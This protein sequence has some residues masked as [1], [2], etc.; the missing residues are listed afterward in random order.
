MSKYRIAILPGDGVGKDVVEATMIVLNK[1]G[2]RRR[3]RLRRHRLGVLVQGGERPARPDHQAAQGDRRLPLRG[4]HLQAQGGRRRPSSTRRSGARACPISAPSSACARNSTSTHEP[5]ALQGLSRQSPQLQGRHRPGHLP[6]EHRGHVR[7]RRVLPPA[8]RSS[9]TPWPTHPKM[10]PFMDVPLDEIAVSTRIMTRKGCERIVRAAFEFARKAKRRSVTLVEKPNVL[11]ETGGLM[12]DTA[13]ARWPRTIPTS[14]SRTPTSTPCAC[15]WSRTPS[16]T[17]SSWPRTS[18]ATSSPTW[19]PSSSAGWASPAAATSA[20]STPSSSR[21]TARRPKYAGMYKV[22]PIATI[23]GRQADA[24]LAGRDGQ[25]RGRS[26]PPS[27]RS[28]RKARSGPTTWAA[29]P[30]PSTWAGP[31]PPSSERRRLAWATP[32]SRRSSP[33]HAGEAAAGPASSGWTWTSARPAI[34]AAPTWSRTTTANTA[35]PRWPIRPRPSSPSTS[36]RPACTL[37]YADNQQA[38]RDFARKHGMTRLR[39][40]PGHRLARPDRGGAGPSRRDR[41]RHGQPHE[42]PR[43]GRLLRPGHGRRGHRL[44]LQD[45]DGPGSRSPRAS[46]SSSRAARRPRATAKDLTLFLCRELGTQADRPALGRVLRRGRPRPRPGRPHHALQHD[47][48]DGRDHRLHSRAQYG[49]CPRNVE[50]F[51]LRVGAPT[52]GPD[53]DAATPR[54]STS[55]STGLGPMVAAPP[56][57]NTVKPVGRS[58]RRPHRFGLHRLLHQ[59][60]DRGLRPRP[61]TSCAAARSSRASC[62]RSSRPPAAST[63]SCW[64]RASWAISSPPGPSSS[65]PGCGGC[66][67]GHVGLTGKGEVEISTGQPQ[68]P[69]QAGQGPGLPGL[70]GRRG[71]LLRQGR[72]RR[73][74]GC[75]T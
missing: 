17:T 57:P 69:R 22:N 18:S 28:S 24:R 21:P 2:R 43:R 47:H 68:F 42:H 14:S 9:G 45:R 58:P 26:R 33:A 4:H 12:L 27:P 75:L 40:G 66:A 20:T 23:P 3:I 19:P 44:R 36:A 52:F 13:S 60:P 35:K 67:E 72:D 15:G 71:R 62:S 8:R 48:R 25:G 31:S 6:G 37:K 55:T 32:S 34:S 64:T 7:R 74:G 5:P 11:R 38:C 39:R 10:K 70:A 51:G 49:I 30:R 61:P 41:R 16:T 63:R 29:S 73:P 53:P 56:S 50:T 59:R 54:R 46:R 1:L 65:I